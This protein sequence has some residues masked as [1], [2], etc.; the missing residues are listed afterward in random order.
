MAEY[1]P[2]WDMPQI[3]WRQQ[4]SFESGQVPPSVD[5]TAGTQI[6]IGPIAREWLYV[7]LGALDQL[8]NPSSWIV[9][10]DDAM[11]TTLR[12][13]DMLRE[14]IAVGDCGGGT[15][16]LRFTADCGLET[17]SDGGA[18]WVGVPGWTTYFQSCVQKNVVPP[19]PDN[20]G[21]L[22][23]QQHMC[24]LS[25]F[26]ASRVIELAMQAFVSSYNDNLEALAMAS[27]VQA[28]IGPYFPYENL[29]F[30]AV[31]GAYIYFTAGTIADLTAAS[32]D[33]AL[34]ADV[35]AAIFQAVKNDGAI[36]ETNYAVMITNLCALTY[37]PAVAV[38]AI[39]AFIT[40]I[41]LTNLQQLASAGVYDV[42]DCSALTNE[43]CYE[44]DFLASN[45]GWSVEAGQIGTWV[46]GVGWR[47][48]DNPSDPH[49][50][51]LITFTLPSH[52]TL[53]GM[54]LEYVSDHASSSPVIRFLQMQSPGGTSTFSLTLSDSL[55]STTPAHAGLDAAGDN[56]ADLL[57]VGWGCDTLS[58]LA[59]I[60]KV[61]IK[62]NGLNPFGA[63]NCSW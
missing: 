60:R 8:R 22:P 30:Q 29:F 45:G 47:A 36:T 56:A 52:M 33:A 14:L 21:N 10:D 59:A 16:M 12:R 58:A 15:P 39:C 34:W 7:V 4:G 40:H 49:V 18:T 54:D 51:V 20:P 46:A 38:N 41:G 61:H 28:I 32:T 1:D 11:F 27:R 31:D 50:S 25:G 63:D 2:A 53:T 48:D 6:C 3:N 5:P 24:N 17:S 19:V 9:S 62:G 23:V 37:T 35:T 13:V 26:L 57:R 43:W 42:V 55:M 44:W